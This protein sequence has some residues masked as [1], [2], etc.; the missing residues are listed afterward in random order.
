MDAPSTRETRVIATAK[1][2]DAIR[3]LI[4][5]HA[6]DLWDVD[7]AG[8]VDWDD[9]TERFERYHNV[10]LPSDYFDPAM[11]KV[12]RIARHAIREARA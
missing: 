7:D 2:V 6:A 3:D 11:R 5:D 1:D 9:W 4:E 8:R 12:Q 10:E